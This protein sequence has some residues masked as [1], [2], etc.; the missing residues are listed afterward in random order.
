MGKVPSGSKFSG[1]TM[2]VI[3]AKGD[4]FAALIIR[5]VVIKRGDK[6]GEGD[7]L[8][9][10]GAGCNLL[11]RDFQVRLGLGVI[12]EEGKMVVIEFCT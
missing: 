8:F 10:P 5:Q 11:G 12:L 4:H 1:S 7:I 6:E 3:G 9:A 2:S